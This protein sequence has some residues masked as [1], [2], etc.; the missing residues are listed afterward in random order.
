MNA[1]KTVTCAFNLVATL[2]VTAL[3]IA[4]AP[5]LGGC[6]AADAIVVGRQ[7]SAPY[8]L[9]IVVQNTGGAPIWSMP[10]AAG[11]ALAKARE[12]GGTVTV[13]LASGSPTCTSYDFS[14]VVDSSI[15]SER[16]ERQVL[17]QLD[18]V[19]DAPG[20]DMLK[21]IEV[22]VSSIA[23]LEGE[24]EVVVLG[25][26][27]SDG[28]V[29]DMTN[30]LLESDARQVVEYYSA[31]DEL[32]DLSGA[33]IAWYGMGSTAGD[34]AAPSN[35]QRLAMEKLWEA[36]LSECGA[37]V[38]LRKESVAS[39]GARQ[40]VPEVGI[41][42]FPEVEPFKP[43]SWE[44]ATVEYSPTQLGFVGD[45]ATFSD[46]DQAR[47]ALQSVAD[48]LASD[49]SLKAIVTAS[50][51]SYPWDPSWPKRLS[52]ERAEA[53]KSQLVEMGVEADRVSAVGIGS[54]EPDD[55]DE[56]GLQIPEK[57]AAKR[58]VVI[59]IVAE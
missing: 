12:T 15:N 43:S 10:P 9:A 44:G 52:E 14:Q 8:N 50:S 45:E 29:L 13:T 17:Q 49:A 18:S 25:S 34:Q 51:A 28:G 20:I 35:S 5:L 39:P 40:T 26:G 36:V 33:V 2:M 21:S 38:D 42:P 27:V 57:S 3:V 19:A 31:H 23:G 22:G 16:M 37:K 56:N 24:S 48:L 11:E 6:A 1:K 7:E 4:V 55:L 32:P 59:E 41:V 53:V 46:A 30:G 58:R 54:G 47:T